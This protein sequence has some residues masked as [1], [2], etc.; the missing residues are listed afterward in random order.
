[1]IGVSVAG[2]AEWMRARNDV[3]TDNDGNGPAKR[4]FNADAS[5]DIDSSRQA[6]NTRNMDRR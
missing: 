4:Y 6:T 1:M 3:N 2:I 5:P